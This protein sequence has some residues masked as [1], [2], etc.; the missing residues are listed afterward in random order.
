MLLSG[1][2]YVLRISVCL[3]TVLYYVITL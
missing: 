1:D 3:Y 2:T